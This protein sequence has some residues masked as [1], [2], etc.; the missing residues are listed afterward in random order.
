MTFVTML[1]CYTLIVGKAP[2]FRPVT[3]PS[4]SEVTHP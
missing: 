4:V 2:P 1:L 3:I